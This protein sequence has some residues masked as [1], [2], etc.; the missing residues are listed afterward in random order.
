[1]A[2]SDHEESSAYIFLKKYADFSTF[3]KTLGSSIEHR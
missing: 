3:C 2:S 1:M